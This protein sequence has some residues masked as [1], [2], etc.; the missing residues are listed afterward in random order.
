MCPFCFPISLFISRLH[1]FWTSVPF[2]HNLT[3]CLTWNVRIIIISTWILSNIANL[4]MYHFYSMCTATAFG[5]LPCICT[6]RN[7]YFNIP[8]ILKDALF[9]IFCNLLQFMLLADLAV[10]LI[11]LE[12][13]WD[14]RQDPKEQR[15]FRNLQ[16]F[17]Y[18]S[19]TVATQDSG[20]FAE[21]ILFL[22]KH[23]NVSFVSRYNRRILL[24]CFQFLQYIYVICCCFQVAD[25]LSSVFGDTNQSELAA[26]ASYALAFPS[27]F[28]ALVDTYDVSC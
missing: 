21:L 26:F 11:F 10:V 9:N 25:S 28:L 2:L 8:S 13:Q 3:L 19:A 20:I 27:N 15:W 5:I 1:L 22:N 12:P 17:C 7:S 18:F 4:F 6:Y 23:Q 16:G 14:P 24:C